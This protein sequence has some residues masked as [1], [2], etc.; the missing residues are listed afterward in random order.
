MDDVF[1]KLIVYK[2]IIDVNQDI[3]K[4]DFSNFYI[5]NSTKQNGDAYVKICKRITYKSEV[6]FNINLSL[7]NVKKVD[8]NNPSE[9][10]LEKLEKKWFKWRYKNNVDI[11]L[12]KS[13]LKN[14]GLI[15]EPYSLPGN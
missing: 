10:V 11:R 14:V 1:K 12:I 8:I 3:L 15:L 6:I 5:S 7:G 9:E 4:G 2:E 13:V